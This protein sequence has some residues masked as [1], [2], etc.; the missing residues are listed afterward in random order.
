M[1]NT[2]S[3][4]FFLFCI[5]RSGGTSIEYSSVLFVQLPEQ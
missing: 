5:L 4:F 1:G 2:I 3:L